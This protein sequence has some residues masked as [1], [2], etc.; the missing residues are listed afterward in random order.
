M[1][2]DGHHYDVRAN[3]NEAMAYD[4]GHWSGGDR[5]G[6]LTF[7]GEWATQ[8]GKPTPDLNAGLA[9][10]AWLMGLERNSD[11]VPIECYAPLFVNV[12]PGASQ[13]GTNLIGYDALHSFGSPSY[14]AQAMLG[15]NKGDT[16]LPAELKVGEKTAATEPVAHGGIGIGTWHTAVEYKDIEVT[17]PEGKTALKPDLTKDLSG[18]NFSGDK[19]QAQDGT[20]KPTVPNDSN[21]A[22]TGDASWTDYTVKLKARKTGGDEGFL[23]LW[24]VVD[25][26]NY[27]WWNVGGWGNSRTQCEAGEGGG[28]TA[29]GPTSNF[30]VE[31]GKWYSL[32]LE[33]SGRHVRCFVDDK[34]ITDATEQSR[35]KGTPIFASASYVTPSHEVI[36]KVVNM[37]NDSLDA[38]I[39]LRGVGAV[40]AGRA[41]VLSG[42][43]KDVNTVD[44]PT[45]VAPKE[46]TLTD[47]AAS[48]HRTFPAHSLTL[49]RM[50]ATAK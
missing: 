32:R 45:K 16:V 17:T 25:E 39:N 7:V 24:H 6:P 15:Q 49:L 10:A 43:P 20:V 28:R 22:T 14:Y 9:D 23:I 37:E 50:G 36:V 41:I 48:F 31:T 21:W 34:L 42:E 44:E 13:W 29:Y 11:Q 12:N 19:W 8:E 2:F 40:T 46:E 30:K 3:K 18:W 4:G 47:A 38:T 5:D 26:D 35:P 1:A 33:V 27:C